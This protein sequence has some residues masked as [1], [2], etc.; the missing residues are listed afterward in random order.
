MRSDLELGDSVG[1]LETVPGPDQDLTVGGDQDD[2]VSGGETQDRRGEDSCAEYD[3]SMMVETDPAL[4]TQ[5]DSVST[6]HLH[7]LSPGPPPPVL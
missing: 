2:L 4:S 6:V 5:H 1:L 3:L 7:L